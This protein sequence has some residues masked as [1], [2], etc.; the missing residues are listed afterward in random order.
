MYGMSVRRAASYVEGVSDV[1]QGMAHGT[2][3][4]AFKDQGEANQVQKNPRGII[5]IAGSA[6]S[7]TRR[8]MQVETIAQRVTQT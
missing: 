6:R 5:F 4:R 3:F 7:E 2:E 8:H 1:M